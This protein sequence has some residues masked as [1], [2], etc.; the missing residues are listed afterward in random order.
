MEKFVDTSDYESLVK[1]MCKL[2]NISDGDLLQFTTQ[3]AFQHRLKSEWSYYDEDDEFYEWA[4]GMV[5]DEGDL[6]I[7]YITVHHF[8]RRFETLDELKNMP[9]YNVFSLLTTDS[10]FASF[11]NRYGYLRIKYFKIKK[12][13]L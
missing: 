1:T 2:L 3:K 9:L 4:K 13:N 7:E 5:E 10:S 6:R 12:N 11:F 8:G